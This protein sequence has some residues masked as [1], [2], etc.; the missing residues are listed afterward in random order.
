M[1]D[2]L[3]NTVTNVIATTTIISLVIENLNISSRD[4][5]SDVIRYYEAY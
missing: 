3:H 2:M 1:R 5:A 4:F